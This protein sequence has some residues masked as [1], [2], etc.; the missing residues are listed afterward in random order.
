[1]LFVETQQ[2]TA[3]V[4]SLLSDDEYR[5]LQSELAERPDAGVVIPGT[6]G[7]R[8]LRSGIAGRG[9]R[10]GVR[11]ID[12]WA[13]S[14]STILLLFLFAKNERDDLTTDQKATLRRIVEAEYP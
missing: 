9:K 4:H 12:Y 2:F 8:K 6:G 13:Q 3:R 1:V 7:L 10:G 5:G 14:R 11:T